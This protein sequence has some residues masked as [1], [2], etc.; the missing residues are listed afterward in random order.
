MLF[1]DIGIEVFVYFYLPRHVRQHSSS[2]PLETPFKMLRR[3]RFGPIAGQVPFL[4]AVGEVAG[5]DQDTGHSRRLQHSDTRPA[6]A[7]PRAVPPCFCEL[8]FD[9][10]TE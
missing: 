1:K 2:V 8:I 10:G 6:V 5:L 9:K 4:F 7:L 3:P